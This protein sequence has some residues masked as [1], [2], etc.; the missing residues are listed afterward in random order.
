M[1]KR[2]FQFLVETMLGDMVGPLLWPTLVA[3]AVFLASFV[4]SIPVPLP[5]L[6]TAMALAFAATATGLLRVSEWRSVNTISGKMAMAGLLVNISASP[7]EDG[8]LKI[9]AVNLGAQWDNLARFPIEFCVDDFEVQIGDRVPTGD[10]G[11]N[12]YHEIPEKG[13]G[14][15]RGG[16]IKVDH[17]PGMGL[18]GK[19]KYKL[20]Y[21]KKHTKRT[22]YLERSHLVSIAPSPD[23][24]TFVIHHS[25][26]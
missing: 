13:R 10:K 19:I 6:L 14:F 24:K 12:R 11:I 20:H 26:I 8:K 25:D 1:L 15:H 9:A 16:D 18:Q 23:G 5:Y 7:Q 17:E 22:E 21:R 2:V 3:A 4:S